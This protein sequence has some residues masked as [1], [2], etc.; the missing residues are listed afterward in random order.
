[1]AMTEV[2]PTLLTSED[3]YL[4]NEGRALRLYEKLGAHRI[5]SGDREGVYFAVWAPDAEAVSVI[6]DFNGWHAGQTPLQPRGESGI[7]EGFVAGLGAGAVYKYHVSS[8]LSGYTVEKADPLAARTEVPPRTA[9]I[10]WDL[11]YEWRDRCWMD[12]RRKRQNLGAPISIYELH[13][14]SWRRVPEEGGRSLN[15]R[16]I[17]EPLAD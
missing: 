17:A 16:E 12:G 9:S 2:L 7:W 15:Y 5:A 1:M 11:D 10:V 3:I 14:A 6:G 8:R 13:M 4:F